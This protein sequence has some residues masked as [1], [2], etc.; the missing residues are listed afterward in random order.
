MVVETLIEMRKNTEFVKDLSYLKSLVEESTRSLDHYSA[1][2]SGELEE[3]SLQA[4]SLLTYR[5]QLQGAIRELPITFYLT[6]E[7]EMNE[8]FTAFELLEQAQRRAEDARLA[9][10]VTM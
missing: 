9:F 6:H 2:H 10:T 8:V 3:I 7:T 4:A 5:S 1:G